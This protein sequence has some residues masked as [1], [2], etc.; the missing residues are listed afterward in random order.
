MSLRT[1]HAGWLDLSVDDDLRLQR[2][3]VS[4]EAARV[5]AWD[6]Y[7]RTGRL[8]WGAG[9]AELLGTSALEDTWEGL[10]RHVELRDRAGVQLAL[11][12]ALQGDGELDLVVAA[13]EAGERPRDLAIRARVCRDVTG[14]VVRVS[15]ACVAVRRA[16]PSLTAATIV[17]DLNNLL[18]RVVGNASLAARI[19][20]GSSALG[21]HLE[22]IAVAGEAAA[23]LCRELLGQQRAASLRQ[24]SIGLN[25]CVARALQL[26][27]PW[28]DS[29]TGASQHLV[30]DLPEVDGDEL[31]LRQVVFNLLVNAAESLPPGAEALVVSTGL[32]D[33]DLVAL[34]ACHVRADAAA[35]GRYVFVEVS[36]AGD[37]MDARALEQLFARRTTTKA[38][39]DGHGLGLTLVA[40]I[41]REHGGAIVVHSSPGFGTT[42][43]VLLPGKLGGLGGGRP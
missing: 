18:A 43:R 42:I 6:W 28:L 10:L 39:G 1:D 36:D 31:Q 11:E 21:R 26:A 17:H 22:D 38:E 25:A 35:P 34:G 14:A 9:A 3:Q 15:G 4:L 40:Q 23:T 24:S 8:E 30:R 7:P 19:A 29:A 13:A 32:A 12:A 5:A 37:G 27:R 33:L 20:P 2:L 16:D 41:V